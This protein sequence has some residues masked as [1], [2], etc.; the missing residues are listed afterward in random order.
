MIETAHTK[1]CTIHRI[2][3]IHTHTQ[4]SNCAVLNY[5]IK[6]A[7]SLHIITFHFNLFPFIATK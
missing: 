3:L 7:H 5:I 6:A 4:I 2:A 1:N